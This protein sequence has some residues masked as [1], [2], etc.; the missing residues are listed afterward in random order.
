MSLQSCL[1]NVW[2]TR[3]LRPTESI[4]IESYNHFSS[5]L[6]STKYWKPICKSVRVQLPAGFLIIEKHWLEVYRQILLWLTNLVEECVKKKKKKKGG[7]GVE[8]KV[9]KK[10]G[11]RILSRIGCCKTKL[12]KILLITR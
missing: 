9:Q 5:A 12:L 2:P 3:I 6:L 11:S 8:V 10:G 7:G 4:Q 1:V